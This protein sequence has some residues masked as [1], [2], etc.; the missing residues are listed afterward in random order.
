MLISPDTWRHFLKPRLAEFISA[1]K[2][3]NPG[4]KIAYHSDGCIYPV[5]P[6][7]IEIGLDILN[8]IQPGSMDPVKL[9]KEYE[10]ANPIFSIQI[11]SDI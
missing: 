5:I 4:I 2:S 7:L 10:H 8:P 3:I 1:L 9:K 6:D 11:L